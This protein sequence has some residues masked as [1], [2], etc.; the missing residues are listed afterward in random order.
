MIFFLSFFCGCLIRPE[1]DLAV[2]MKRI[3]PDPQNCLLLYP[4]Y[5]SLSIY[6]I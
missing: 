5:E 1:L 6:G 2:K 4:K 3:H